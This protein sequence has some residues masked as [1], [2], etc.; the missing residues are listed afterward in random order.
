MKRA[1]S[2]EDTRRQG[3]TVRLPSLVRIAV[4][5]IAV[6]F[7]VVF[8]LLLYRYSPPGLFAF[9]SGTVN[10][11][12]ATVLAYIFGVRN[13]FKRRE[14]ELVR[15]R[16]LDGGIDRIR[17]YCEQATKAFDRNLLNAIE[18]LDA[19]DEGTPPIPA[20]KFRKMDFDFA[21]QI[22]A[23]R[24]HEL[25]GDDVL[26]G[27][28]AMIAFDAGEVATP[29]NEPSSPQS[30]ELRSKN[31]ADA[32]DQHRQ[33]LKQ[34]RDCPARAKALTAL[35]SHLEGLG[36][37]IDGQMAL[38][39]AAV[40]RFPDSSDAKIIVSGLKNALSEYEKDRI[41]CP[42]GTRVW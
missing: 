18:T 13:Y 5:C 36:Y 12:I 7:C 6:S 30:E 25:L 41:K 1:K 26:S 39:W 40:A 28:L 32:R 35:V 3:R 20:T 24:A 23:H 8:I 11:L 38:D 15:Q 31:G 21:T 17:A 9:F 29:F 33:L 42:P 10:V 37:L 16:Y 27:W 4:C 34:Y 2:C 14:H 22:A 19:L